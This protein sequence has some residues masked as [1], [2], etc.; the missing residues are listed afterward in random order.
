MSLTAQQVEIWGSRIRRA[1][2]ARR[3]DKKK[4]D[5]IREYYKGNYFPALAQTHRVATNWIFAAVRQMMTALYYRDPAM[6]FTPESELGD[7]AAPI[8]EGVI[9][10][11][12]KITDSVVHERRALIDALKYGHGVVKHGYS[13]QYGPDPAFALDLKG[14]AKVDLEGVSLSQADE[15]AGLPLG[16][17]TEHNAGVKFGHT[18]KRVISPYDFL[19]DPEAVWPEEARWMCER[20]RRPI[21]ECIRDER[22][23]S[24]A[25][26]ELQAT[27]VHKLD[28]NEHEESHLEQLDP[29]QH[30]E[31]VTLYEIWDKE[32]QRILVVSAGCTAPLLEI[33]YPYTYMPDGPY[34]ILQF[35]PRDDSFFGI[36][37]ADT[38]ATQVEVMNKL[39]TQMMDHLQ[40]MA[41]IR[42]VYRSGAMSREDATRLVESNNALVEMQ[43]MVDDDIKKVVDIFPYIP[44]AAD[45]WKLAELYMKDFQQISGISD[46]SLGRG[47]GTKTA[48][49]ISSMDRHN[50]LRGEDMRATVDRFLRNS[51]RKQV[52]LLRQYWP[53]E[54]VTPIVGPDGRLWNM[55]QV[56]GDMVRAEYDVDIEPGST[57]RVDKR[58]R[59]RQTIDAIR[60]LVPLI[61]YM[62]AQGWDLDM[63]ELV[64]NYLQNTD[65]YS[66][67]EKVVKPY[68]NQLQGFIEYLQSLGYNIDPQA[69]QAFLQN[70]QGGATSG[71][72]VNKAPETVT[73]IGQMPTEG[74]PFQSGRALSEA[75]NV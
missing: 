60:E 71:S 50:E 24:V 57:E 2:S 28:G 69:I 49:E 5:R 31:M 56:T 17:W 10:Y 29:G 21:L 52:Q 25:R 39:R 54:R 59:I 42:G 63:P 46:I 43:N 75:Q 55:L 45:C 58:V 32:T 12:R 65:V 48:T 9:R 13:F 35:F 74:A 61:P 16:G 72:S 27:G 18:W 22:Y 51:T 36:A 14:D 6:F 53:P 3:D 8:M 23:A 34:E 7:I 70:S 73:N 47:R 15:S 33:D 67:P 4:W 20:F 38:F 41:G 62:Q 40:R 19:I 64:K 37:Y 26:A 11:E 1:F 66:N 44:I 68:T 30:S